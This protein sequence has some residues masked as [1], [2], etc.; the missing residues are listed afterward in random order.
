VPPGTPGNLVASGPT[1]NSVNLSWGASSGTVTQY[2][3]ER[4]QGSSCS[5]FGQVGT[6]TGT[7]YTS[8]GL[9]AS[10]TYRFRVRASNSRGN[11]GYSNVVN[12]TTPAPPFNPI[13]IQAEDHGTPYQSSQYCN[14]VRGVK[15]GTGVDTLNAGS[16][17]APNA[18]TYRITVFY[19]TQNGS[20]TLELRVD[21]S[22]QGSDWTSD[23]CNRSVSRDVALQAGSHSIQ[24]SREGRSTSTRHVVIDRIEITRL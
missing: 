4:C 7:S 5:N 9:T 23:A 2:L 10:T 8:T 19:G 13:T 15:L 1:V 21:G 16:F 22:D 12:A 3:V 20:A 11:S 14:N 6:A 24:V 17:T 18:A